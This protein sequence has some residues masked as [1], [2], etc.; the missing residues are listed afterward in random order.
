[1]EAGV[2]EL[3]AEICK[4]LGNAKR[5]EILNALRDGEMTVTEIIERV[6][7]NKT[8]VSQHL[9]V[10]RNKKI[11]AT[12]RE[13]TNIYYCVANPKVIRAC[14]LMRQVLFEQLAETE[15]FSKKVKAKKMA[16][17]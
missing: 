10:M 15:L 14:D 12:R 4:T 9:A 6:N 11:L 5:L 7:A 16:V 1:M 2:F 13:G 3:H 17:R 8:N